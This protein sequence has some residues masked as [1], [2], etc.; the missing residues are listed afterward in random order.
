[1]AYDQV[2]VEILRDD[3]SQ[4]VGIT[5][6]KMFGGLAFMHQGNMLCGVSPKGV[7]FRVGKEN[8]ARALAIAGTREMDFTG[9]RM[10]GFVEVSEEA[11]ADDTSR[12]GLMVLALGFVA[13]LPAK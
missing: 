5:E 2:L 1:M 12:A 9:R 6:K 7:M 11:F 13:A 8:E 3:L 10:G 4:E